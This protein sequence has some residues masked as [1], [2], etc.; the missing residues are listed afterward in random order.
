MEGSGEGH[1]AVRGLVLIRFCCREI[2]H[3]AFCTPKWHKK[4]YQYGF[5]EAKHIAPSALIW[6]LTRSQFVRLAN[7]TLF[8]TGIPSSGWAW[9]SCAYFFFPLNIA[10]PIFDAWNCCDHFANTKR[11][12]PTYEREQIKGNSKKQI[13]SLDILYLKLDWPLDFLL[14][15]KANFL[16]PPWLV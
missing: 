1:T 14:W 7:L 8:S 10:V 6:L 15:K 13:W 12:K 2:F 16:I 4:P 11:V 5:L 9:A 3:C